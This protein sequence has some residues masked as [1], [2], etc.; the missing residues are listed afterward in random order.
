[1]AGVAGQK[2]PQ[3]GGAIVERIDAIDDVRPVEARDEG[4]ALAQ[5][6]PLDD[7]LPGAQIGGGGERHPRNGREPLGERR[8]GQILGAEIVAP[9]AHAMGL[10]DGEQRQPH[11]PDHLV[12]EARHHQPFRRHVQEIEGAGRDGAGDAV[13]FALRSPP[14]SRPPRDAALAERLDLIL[15]QGDQRRHHDGDAGPA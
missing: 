3:L 12:E 10:V 11:A 6:Q 4:A 13:D 1:M 9:F 5:M 15:H 7:L 2:A 8:Q 14:N